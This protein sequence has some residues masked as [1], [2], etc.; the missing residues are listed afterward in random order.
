MANTGTLQARIAYKVS[1]SGEPVDINGNLTSISGRRQAIALLVGVANPDPTKYEIEYTFNTGQLIEGTPTTKVD[2]TYCPVSVFT[3]DKNYIVLHPG[4]VSDI[5]N[6]FASYGWQFV[7]PFEFATPSPT[8]AGGNT[9]PVT[10]TR[11][12]TL[13]Q[14]YMQFKDNTTGEVK[15]VYVVNTDALGWILESGTWNNL[16]FWEAAGIWNY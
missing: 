10:L 1:P 2:I 7:G 11:T 15:T 12:A 4:K 6:I 13:G 16:R 3:I 8:S 5:I 9:T 14:G